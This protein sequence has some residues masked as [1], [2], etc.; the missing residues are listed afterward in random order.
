[1]KIGLH[2][3]PWLILFTCL[4]ACSP[5]ASAPCTSDNW[6]I[7]GQVDFGQPTI[8]VMF[9]DPSFGIATD[10]GSGIHYTEDGGTTWEFSTDAGFSR[11]ALD[12]DA[13][14]LWHVGYGGALLRS[15]DGA[16]TWEHISQLPHSA[17]IEYISFSDLM[18]G[19]FVSTEV[20]KLF[21][22]S[23]GGKTWNALPLPDDMGRVASIQQR[24]TTEGYLLDTAGKLFITHDGGSDW[25]NRSLP[26]VEGLAIPDQNHS[27]ALRFMDE[28]DGLVALNRV[29]GGT[30][31]VYVLRTTDGGSTWTE[32]LLPV[33]IGMFFLTRDGTLLT[34][35]DLLDH[36]KF[37]LLCA[38]GSGI[39]INFPMR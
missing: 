11:V 27:V 3:L 8:S 31:R 17:H 24:T 2:S 23:D 18:N 6:E 29:G 28:R 32:E 14:T 20:R 9:R 16:H 10:L 30:S 36:S 22:T 34:H 1:M 35:V 19:W 33:S 37:T 7:I 38:P 15:T 39:R 21:V 12:M 13:N 5:Q 4:A 26:S 25:T